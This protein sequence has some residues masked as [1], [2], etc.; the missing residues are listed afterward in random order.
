MYIARMKNRGI[1]ADKRI[2]NT[3][4]DLTW[5]EFVNNDIIIIMIVLL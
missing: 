5:V 3:L 2:H 1:L 4:E